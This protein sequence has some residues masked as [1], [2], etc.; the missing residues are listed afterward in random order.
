MRVLLVDPDEGFAS[1][2]TKTVVG[3]GIDVVH[4]S[5]PDQMRA[6]MRI[7]TFDS[8]VVDLSLRRMNGFDVA[9]ELRMEAPA[10]DLEIILVSPRHKADSREVVSLKRD[11]DC[12]FFLNKPIDATAMLN[13]LKAKRPSAKPTAAPASE[14]AAKPAKTVAPPPVAPPR[15]SKKPEHKPTKKAEIDWDNLSDLV[16]LWVDRKSGMLVLAGKGGGAAPL[17]DGGLVDDAGRAVVKAS[18]LGGVLAFKAGVQEGPGDWTRM[19]RL[20]FKGARAGCDARTLRRYLHA[21][22]QRTDRTSSARSLPLS[23]DA[24]AFVGRIDSKSTVAE[25]LESGNL[26]VGEVSKDVIALTRMGLVGLQSL[27]EGG[28]GRP[29]GTS[30][31]A[32]RGQQASGI[33]ETSE[34]AQLLQ[35]LQREYATIRDAPPPVVLGVPADADKALVDKASARQGQRYAGIIARRDLGKPVR[36]LAL[37]I[38]KRVDQAHRNFNFGS[39]AQVEAPMAANQPLDEIGEMLQ[40]GRAKIASKDWEGAD[41][42]LAHAHKKRIDHVSVLANLG[43]AR[44]HNPSIDLETR[45]EEGKDFLLLAE[46]FDPLDSDGQ[47]YLAQLLLVS[48]RLDA[49]EQ[50]AARAAKADPE[51]GARHAL[52]RKIRSRLAHDKTK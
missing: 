36:H 34:E 15:A 29:E 9:R 31:P 39:N 38:A 12:R 19:G 48:N 52:L 28:R 33:N 18:V 14:P 13:A 35:R 16:A 44:L 37:D 5:S 23:A 21:V 24:R 51:D 4:A 2:L 50:R 46:Q 32:S 25:I 30:I 22:P 45:T 41:R 47:Y 42:V 43:W 40:E 20:L 49:A 6:Q 17:C 10:S 8:V 27:A 1:Q 3:T 7:R 26:P 11:T